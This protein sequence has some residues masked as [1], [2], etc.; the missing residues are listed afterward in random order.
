MQIAEQKTRAVRWYEVDFAEEIS[1]DAMDLLLAYL[2]LA[3][4]PD[5]RMIEREIAASPQ[6]CGPNSAMFK[7]CNDGLKV[8][9]RGS[10]ICPDVTST[11]RRMVV[12]DILGRADGARRYEIHADVRRNAVILPL[13][14]NAGLCLAVVH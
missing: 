14:E 9:R 6:L 10:D 8:V 11:L 1:A 3:R 4:N 13:F 5:R 2:S 12:E 7:L